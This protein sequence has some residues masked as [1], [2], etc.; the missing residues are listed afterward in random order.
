[1]AGGLKSQSGLIIERLSVR[2]TVL[3]KYY[4]VFLCWRSLEISPIRIAGDLWR[5]LEISGDLQL[6]GR[7]PWRSTAKKNISPILD[8]YLCR[9][10]S[11]DRKF[12]RQ[13]VFWRNLKKYQ[14]KLA[15]ARF[16]QP[17]TAHHQP[18]PTTDQQKNPFTPLTT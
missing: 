17:A 8:T 10:Y 14:A 7:S 11:C 3:F 1:L 9:R 18:P 2:T 5:S 16:L 12:C 13:Q 15:P 4:D 6:S